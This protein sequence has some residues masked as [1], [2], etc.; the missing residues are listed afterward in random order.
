MVDDGK[1]SLDGKDLRVFYHADQNSLPVEIDR[2]V[3][4]L[5]TATTTVQFRTQRMIPSN[6]LDDKSYALI[7]GGKSTLR[8]K[9]NKGNVFAF[10][11]DFSSSTLQDWRRKW[12]E[13]TVKNGS[14]FGRTG[15]SIFGSGEVG[16]YL[17]Q[18]KGWGDIELELDLMETGSN[19]VYP[20]PFFRVEKPSLRHTTA[21][22]FE[23]MTDQKKCTMR[24]Y[25]N[26]KDGSWMYK[27]N[28]PEPLVKNK[29]FHFKYQLQGNKISQWA[30]GVSIQNAI[31]ESAWMIPRGTIG[32][33]C[34]NSSPHGC[35]TFYDNI[36]VRFLVDSKPSVSPGDIC[37]LAHHKHLIVGEEGRPADSCKQIHDANIIGK[38]TSSAKNGVYWIKTSL[39][40][41][42]GSP[43]FCDM[44]NGGWT[45]V[46][47]ITGR[48]GN[49]Y[50]T[51]LVQNVNINLLKSSSMNSGTEYASLDA[52]LLAVRH[53]S[54]IM[55][56]SSDNPSGVG[57]KW[58]R[59]EMPSDREYGT[60]WNHGVGPEK[61][62]AAG[63]SQ[64]TVKAWN[65]Q[66][67]VRQDIGVKMF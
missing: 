48:V 14:L 34:H 57:N 25:V 67:K 21:W 39:T 53:S 45:L 50:N 38:T 6:S 52:R 27:C 58:V 3:K 11:E 37:H 7:F 61:V 4:N 62:K 26:N 64:V 51:W 60:W 5:Y 10:Y 24:P 63:T 28:L 46:G 23:Y 31:V 9:T 33:G 65:G 44:K 43:T 13:W 35:R 30:N 22:W 17:K 55:F 18:G 15:V 47:K 49:I 19:T 16:L 8:V 29:W 54:A 12:G 20:G 1:A 56:S 41:K 59:W 66:T 36:E 40:S 2:I 32:F 42:K